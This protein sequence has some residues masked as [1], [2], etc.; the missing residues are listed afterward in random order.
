MVISLYIDCFLI[1]MIDSLIH[2]CDKDTVFINCL[3]HK[4]PSSDYMVLSEVLICANYAKCHVLTDSF[5]ST[6]T[7][8][9][10]F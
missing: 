10:S 1:P 3:L 9:P 2:H 8:I 5:N 7:L 6:V 4:L